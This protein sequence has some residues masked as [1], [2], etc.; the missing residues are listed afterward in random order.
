M[1]SK[2]LEKEIARLS[3]RRAQLHR[4][5]DSANA[6]LEQA[7]QQLIAGGD[8][9]EGRRGALGAGRALARD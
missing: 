2:E 8:G 1:K 5:L 4:D 9:G 3:E 7:R 6:D